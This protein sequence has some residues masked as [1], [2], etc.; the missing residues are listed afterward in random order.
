MVTLGYSVTDTFVSGAPGPN[1]AIRVRIP[2]WDPRNDL[3]SA[4]ARAAWRRAEDATRTALLTD[5]Q[6]LCEQ[7]GEV[8]ALDP[9]R[10]LHRDRLAYRQE[11]VDQSLAEADAL[12][13][14]TEA[15]QCAKHEWQRAAAKFAAQRLTLARR[16][17]TEGCALGRTTSLP[18]RV[19]NA[20]S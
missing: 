15:A 7:T 6:S 19:G 9:R 8:H 3:K 4:Q 5:L 1:A 18:R 13:A 14:E 12:W 11:Q 17:A 20:L 2:L 16:Y 10:A